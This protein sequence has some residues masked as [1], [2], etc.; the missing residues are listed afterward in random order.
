MVIKE[1]IGNVVVD[2]RPEEGL[3]F[4]VR[5]IITVNGKTVF[6]DI[7]KPVRISKN[8][9]TTAFV[10]DGLIFC[11]KVRVNIDYHVVTVDID[12]LRG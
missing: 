5:C 12:D 7:T 6:D 9:V 11:N 2:V 8:G 1:F 3:N 10:H 4:Y